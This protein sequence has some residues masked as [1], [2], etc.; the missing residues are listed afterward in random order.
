VGGG[1]GGGDWGNKKRAS[2]INAPEKWDS[3]ELVTFEDSA[4]KNCNQRPTEEEN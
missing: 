1:P 3:E 4:K 2:G